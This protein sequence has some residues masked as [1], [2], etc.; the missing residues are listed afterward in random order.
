MREQWLHEGA[1]THMQVLQAAGLLLTAGS[2]GLL[3]LCKLPW[4]AVPVL[5]PE[6]P[7]CSLVADGHMQVSVSRGVD[8]MCCLVCLMPVLELQ[9]QAHAG[10]SWNGSM[11][12]CCQSK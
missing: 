1:I 2:D 11:P 3:V 6:W 4:P 5:E 12:E 8:W 9:A 10:I 7:A